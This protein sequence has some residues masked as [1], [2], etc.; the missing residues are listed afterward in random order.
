MKLVPIC[1][2]VTLFAAALLAQNTQ[3][4]P[5][6]EVASV[7]RNKSGEAG[8]R[9]QIQPGGRF[10]AVNATVRQIIVRAYGI[11]DSE[12]VGAPQWTNS[13]RFDIAAKAERDL[14]PQEFSEMLKNLLRERFQLKVH[15]ATQDQPIYAL[16]IARKDGN[17]GPQLRRSN[18]DC[19]KIAEEA[20]ALRGGAPPEM[21]KGEHQPC[22]IGFSGAGRMFARS[23][24]ISQLLTFFSQV[25][26]RPVENRTGLEGG[27]DVDLTWTSGAV[28]SVAESP[29]AISADLGRP[30]IFTAVQEQLGLKLESVKA[31]LA[32]LVIDSI[33]RPMEN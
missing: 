23:K 3:I 31:P 7:K 6:F 30:S 12:I 9:L 1:L 10:N 20:I 24:P 25:T 11:Q 2:S 28:S 4:S 14:T 27:F 16:V 5:T 21:P 18:V 33:E 26:Q 17:L 29:D 13:E 22:S 8:G 32:T 15:N 19:D